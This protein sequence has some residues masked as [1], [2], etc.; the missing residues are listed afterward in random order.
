[1]MIRTLACAVGVTLSISVQAQR[2]QR[3][4]LPPAGDTSS[5]P[6]ARAI[7]A[8]GGLVA[9]EAT[10]ALVWHGHAVVHANGTDVAIE[11]D[12]RVTPPDSA[13]ATTW[14]QAQGPSSARAL[15]L[16]GSDSYVER[17][18]KK[19]P[20]AAAFAEHER[21]Q[22]YLYEVLRLVSIAGERTVRQSIGPDSAGNPG[23][24]VRQPGRRDVE[25]YF[26]RESARLVHL[27]NRT[28]DPETGRAVVQD[29]W[30]RGTMEARGVRW[31]R[32]IRIR[33]DD[34]PYFDL[35]IDRFDVEAMAQ[36]ALAVAPPALPSSPSA[37]PSSSPLPTGTML[38]KFDV[39]LPG[40]PEE[41]FDAVTGDVSGWWDHTFSSKPYRLYIEPRP[42][43]GFYEIFD[44]DGNGVRHATVTYAHRGKLLRMEGA[45]GLTGLAVTAVH[46]M[47][48]TPVGSDSTTIGFEMHASGEMPPATQPLVDGVWR[49]FLI[50]RFKPYVESGKHKPPARRSREQ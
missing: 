34:Q 43:G 8:H 41:I 24:R 9:L 31:P 35:T 25:I 22:F 17:D 44:R 13:R 40:T 18:G 29:V 15:V 36:P 30:L 49:H 4:A 11:G 1:M 12:W 42:G 33:W 28:N 46:S 48:F 20:M 50:E 26:D 16:A 3:A 37:T 14:V 10:H 6:L 45:L 21:G 23:I 38:V 5:S 27:R 47:V 2:V 7:S 19:E 39:T 32:E